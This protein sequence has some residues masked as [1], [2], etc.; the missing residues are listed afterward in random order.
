MEFGNF[1]ALN[2][3]SLKFSSG[4]LCLLGHN[5]A[6]KTTFINVLTGVFEQSFGDVYVHGSSNSRDSI[7]FGI[8]HQQDV[9]FENMTFTEHMQLICSIRGITDFESI[10]NILKDKLKF[11]ELG[12]YASQLSN[13]NR[14]KLCLSLALFGLDPS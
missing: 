14:R 11:E 2:D 7:Q 4:A 10:L 5:G 1:K 9:L 8:C 12:K 13:G 6:G 3:L